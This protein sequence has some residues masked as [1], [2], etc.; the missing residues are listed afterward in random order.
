MTHPATGVSVWGHRQI[1]ST[2][3]DVQLGLIPPARSQVRHRCTCVRAGVAPSARLG[4]A[5][6]FGGAPPSRRSM[7]PGP[8]VRVAFDDGLRHLKSSVQQR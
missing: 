6:V 2:P 7:R 3:K 1:A 5:G 4:S 8:G